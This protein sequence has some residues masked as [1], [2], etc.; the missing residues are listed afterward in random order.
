V[1]AGYKS[2]GFLPGERLGSGAVIRV[3]VMAGRSSR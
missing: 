3:G 2:A 1:T